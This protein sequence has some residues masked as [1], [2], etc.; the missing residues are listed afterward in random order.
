MTVNKAQS[1][2]TKADKL[3]PEEEAFV[4]IKASRRFLGTGCMVAAANSPWCMRS[5]LQRLHTLL[6]L[7]STSVSSDHLH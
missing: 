6:W 1:F 5:M 4:T 7:C 2:G 3:E